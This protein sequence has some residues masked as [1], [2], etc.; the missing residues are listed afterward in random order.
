M[1]IVDVFHNQD[2]KHV[3]DTINRFE[4]R[5]MDAGLMREL[6]K[7]NARRVKPSDGMQRMRIKAMKTW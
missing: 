4:R 6:Q 1:G 7:D 5:M 3:T 2:R